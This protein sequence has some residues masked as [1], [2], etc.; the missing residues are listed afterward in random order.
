MLVCMFVIRQGPGAH[1]MNMYYFLSFDANVYRSNI[2]MK[3]PE[4]TRKLLNAQD[5]LV[6][7]TS[8]QIRYIKTI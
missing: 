7:K 6:V 5:A 1:I 4:A 2:K 8:Y 3:V